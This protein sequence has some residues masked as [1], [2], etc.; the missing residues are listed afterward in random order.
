VA[1]S[2]RRVAAS[3]PLPNNLCSG[4]CGKKSLRSPEIIAGQGLIHKNWPNLGMRM[5]VCHGITSGALALAAVLATGAA[6]QE[7]Q[8]EIVNE[9]GF[10]IVEFFSH[11]KGEEG[12]GSNMI[13][14]APIADMASQMV[15]FP[16]TGGYCMFSFMAVFDD[17]EA[18][19]SDDINICDLPSFT[20]Y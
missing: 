9:T 16:D 15:V 6:A 11:R 5:N 3:R 20:Y 4:V 18:L 12:W 1:L 8:M 7:R 14:D 19:V 13:P 17:G 10:E 2:I